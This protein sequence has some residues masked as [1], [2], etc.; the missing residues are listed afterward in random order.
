MQMYLHMV[1]NYFIL[2]LQ[3]FAGLRI[4]LKYSAILH[5]MN[6][7]PVYGRFW[8]RKKDILFFRTCCF[9][10][11]WL[12][13]R[14]FCLLVSIWIRRLSSLAEGDFLLFLFDDELGFYSVL[15]ISLSLTLFHFQDLFLRKTRISDYFMHL[16][17]L[18]TIL[19]GATG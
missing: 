10:S 13:G 8:N 1:E 12:F 2:V 5:F 17:L 11:P 9:T 19:N 18:L 4:T 7:S 15:T 16:R 3:I 14:L 6:H